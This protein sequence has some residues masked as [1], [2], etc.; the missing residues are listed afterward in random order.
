VT[1]REHSAD[2]IA[3]AKLHHRS[4]AKD[5]SRLA[6]VLPALGDKRIDDITTA[7][8]ERFLGS[9]Q[10]GDGAVAPATRN[11][12]RDLLSGLFKRAQRLGL[13]PANPVKG[14][15]KLKEPAGRV[16]YLTPE[17]EQ[18]LRDA[19]PGTLHPLVTMALHTGMRW[20]EQARLRWRDAD[21]LTGT[22]TVMHSKNGRTRHIP[23]NALVRSVLYDLGARRRHPADPDELIFAAAYRTTARALELAARAAR[24]MLASAGKNGSHLDGFTWHGLR[25]TWASRL[26]MAGVDPRTLQELGGW[27]TLGMVERYSHLSPDHLRAAVERLVPVADTGGHTEL[28][29]NLNELG[30]ARSVGSSDSSQVCDPIRTEG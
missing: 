15:P 7:D 30:S 8:V 13:A 4:W 18:A 16:V 14:I 24:G 9:L 27:K 25:H 19:L 17:E 5:D 21:L 1:L 22:I 2:Y 6:R 3:W 29:R 11:R 23:M 10:Q 28:G 20:S 12:Y 26:S